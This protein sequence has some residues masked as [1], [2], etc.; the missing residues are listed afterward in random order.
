MYLLCRQIND[1]KYLKNAEQAK[2]KVLHK[3]YVI[4]SKQVHKE[5]F[6][7]LL[8]RQVLILQNVVLATL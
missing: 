8:Q 5:P 4:A 1:E 6:D 3:W 2:R 7:Y